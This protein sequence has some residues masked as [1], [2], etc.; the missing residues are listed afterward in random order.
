MKRNL[1]IDAD[2][3]AYQASAA[4]EHACE[5]AP[6]HWTWHVNFEEVI[7]A[8]EVALM[9]IK[10]RLSGDKLTLCLTDNNHNFRKDVLPS[11]KTHRSTV[12][13][14][15]VLLAVK[16][17][18][19]ENMDG[20]VVPG[21]EGDDVMGILATR[22]T[23]MENIVVSL[24]KDLKTIP[25]NYVRTRAQFDSEGN[26]IMSAW[27]IN[28]VTEDEADKYHL[29]QTL[30][31]DATDGYTGCPGIGVGTA[32]KIINEG[33]MKVP[34]D[35]ELT[36]GPRKGQVEKRFKDVPSDD[37]WEIVKSQ[38]EAA[39]LGEEE[40]L[41]QARCARILRASDY[42]FKNKEVIPWTP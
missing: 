20:I 4:L 28:V 32:E 13:K 27:D 7:N 10:E 19:V 21:L 22:K 38:F 40:A 8:T 11:Y 3:V 37:R 39:G 18:L 1:L 24:D 35:H 29:K 14:P 41:V 36:R 12:R 33:L 34:Y 26:Q 30:S 16:D 25:C 42:D 6:G 9:N 31:G 23:K 15:L 17:W 5:W 2:I